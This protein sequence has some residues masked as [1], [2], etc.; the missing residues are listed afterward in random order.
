MKHTKSSYNRLYHFKSLRS[1]HSTVCIASQGL[2]LYNVGS[3]II[4]FVLGKGFPQGDNCFKIA[5]LFK[6]CSTLLETSEGEFIILHMLLQGNNSYLILSSYRTLLRE[7]LSN[8][9]NV[10]ILLIEGIIF[11]AVFISGSD[12]SYLK[13]SANNSKK[14]QT[15]IHLCNFADLSTAFGADI[16]PAQ[17]FKAYGTFIQTHNRSP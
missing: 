1:L 2:A 10:I 11:D 15:I 8:T 3:V 12:G 9:A 6:N 14:R 17:L 7:K 13:S 16:F 4:G 5:V